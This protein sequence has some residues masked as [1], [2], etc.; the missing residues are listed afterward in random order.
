MDSY[1]QELILSLKWNLLVSINIYRF[2][3][4]VYIQNLARRWLLTSRFIPKYYT[5]SNPSGLKFLDLPYQDAML[6]AK[7]K[8]M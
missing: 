7:R 5:H 3:V 4:L 8:D 6:I 2:R 1:K